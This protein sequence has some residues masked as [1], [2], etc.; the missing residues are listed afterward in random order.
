MAGS[1]VAKLDHDKYIYCKKC[2][3]SKHISEFYI[4]KVS[5]D[6]PGKVGKP[7]AY[8]RTCCKKMYGNWREDNRKYLRYKSYER[9]F[10][11]FPEVI[12]KLLVEQGYKC[13]ICLKVP[14]NKHLS[15]DHNHVTN[16]VRQFLCDKCNKAIG[17]F[18]DSELLIEAALNYL[19]KHK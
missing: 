8:C 11:L 3:Q 9:K 1:C 14:E 17:L 19:R 12:D 7:M 13:A 10:G 5:R 2:E 18:Q 6:R 16:K 4:Q 15:L